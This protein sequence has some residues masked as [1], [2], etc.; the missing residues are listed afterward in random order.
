[1]ILP[2]ILP[3]AVLAALLAGCSSD[4]GGSTPNPPPP[5]PPE[6]EP[7]EQISYQFSVANLTGN[8][9]FSPPTV[10]VT[11]PGFR[12]W[13][14]GTSATPALEVL[15]ESGNGAEF[16]GITEVR[17]LVVADGVLAP[18][19]S[20]TVSFEIPDPEADDSDSVAVTLATMLVNTNDAFTGATGIAADLAPGESRTYLLHA[21]DAGT[22]ANDELA[23][24][25]PG[26]AGDGEGYSASREADVDSVHIH[27]GVLTM[28]ELSGSALDAGHRFDN[29]VAR[30][31]L[32]RA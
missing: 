19:E 30:V 14:I 3:I 31:T 27:P 20:L 10:L 4:D 29:P 17:E 7:P 13:A 24:A 16:A 8:Q 5:P 2:K 26:P 1:M 25:I 15:A 18:G 11:D 12:A 21:Y 28:H 22:E 6:P 32:T 9:P 23:A